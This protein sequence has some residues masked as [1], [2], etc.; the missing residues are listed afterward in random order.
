MS[1]A[2]HSPLLTRSGPAADDPPVAPGRRSSLYAR[3]VSVNALILTVAVTALALSPVTVSF[4]VATEEGLVLAGGLV[5]MVVANAVLL[6]ISF[7]GLAALVR[8]MQALDVLRPQDR[9]PEMG[10]AEAR[11]LI[12]GYNAMLDRLE[13]ERRASTSLSV[14]GQEAERRRIAQELHDEIGQRLTGIL[15]QLGRVRDEAPAALRERLGN[16]QEETRRA[17]DEVGALA[18]QIRPGLLEDLGLLSAISALADSLGEHTDIEVLLPE[19]VPGLGDETELAVYRVAQEALTNAVRHAD[20]THIAVALRADEPHL[21]MTVSDNGK[22]LPEAF[23]EGAGIR[24]MRERALLI[25]GRLTID[26]QPGRGVCVRLQVPNE[27][28]PG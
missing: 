17:L 8:R 4:P 27:P 14:A 5:V 28:S 25:G 20:A 24:G 2:V 12:A 9:L 23:V 7:R 26:S 18:W 21:V 22:G 10:G 13:A 1:P 16:V 3:V 15:L 6:R 19:D 11:T